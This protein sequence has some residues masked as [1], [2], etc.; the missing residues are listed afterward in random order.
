[1][2]PPPRTAFTRREL[3]LVDALRTPHDVQQWLSRLPYNKERLGET[4]LSFRGVTKRGRAHCFEAAL[5]AATILEQ[6]AHP[7]LLLDLESWDDLD[8]VLYLYRERARWGT[9][10]KSRDPA[11]HGRKPVYTSIPALVRSY[12]DGYVDKTGR[13]TA[14]GVLDLR[15]LPRN[16]WRLSERNLRYV[17][18]AL[19]AL[20]HT[21]IHMPDARYRAMHE[22]YLAFKRAHPREKPWRHYD[23]RH[24]WDGWPPRQ[25]K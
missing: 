12:M 24:A 14:W 8:H 13:I 17:E 4:A 22:R 7:P 2:A 16:D 21:P 18:N 19:R 20:P 23:G 3:R 15:D 5:S 25:G 6:H 10:A 9:V 1:M 11:L